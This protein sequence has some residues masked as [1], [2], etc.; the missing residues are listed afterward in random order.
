MTIFVWFSASWPAATPHPREN[1]PIHDLGP[2]HEAFLPPWGVDEAGVFHRI[3][4]IDDAR[5][6]EIFG[7][8]VLRLLVGKELL[9][10]EWAERILSWPHSGFNVHSG[11]G[12]GA[13]SRGSISAAL[14][15]G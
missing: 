1:C 11:R 7:R 6:E 14:T 15:R 9:S 2:V 8:E 10:P 4:G 3:P 12:P 13:L 5:L